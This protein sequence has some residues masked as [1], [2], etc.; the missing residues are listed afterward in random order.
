MMIFEAVTQIHVQMS[1][2]DCIETCAVNTARSL[3]QRIFLVDPPRNLELRIAVSA[4]GREEQGKAAKERG[5][6][7]E[8]VLNRGPG[9]RRSTSLRG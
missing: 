4:R 5:A 7:R 8:L 3:L 6:I 9:A 2:I 1:M